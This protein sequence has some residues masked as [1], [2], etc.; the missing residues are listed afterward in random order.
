MK[1]FSIRNR[2]EPRPA[3]RPGLLAPCHCYALATVLLW[4]SAYVFTK[5][6]MEHFSFASLG[7][8]RCA[9]A[10]VVLAAALAVKKT[11]RP[12]AAELPWF[13][14]SGAAGFA[15]Y[16]LAFNRGSVW[17]NPTT[18]CL[19]ISTAPLITALLARFGLGEGLTA[20]GWGALLSAFGGVAIMMLGEGAVT[21]S[22]GIFWMLL[23]ALLISVYNLV[24]RKLAAGR[25][26]LTITAYSFFS[27]A[28]LLAWGAP[29]ALE[30]GLEASPG[31]LAVAVYLGVFPSALAYLLWV[32]ALALAPRTSAVT[33]YMYLTPL[34]ALLLEYLILAETPGLGTWLGGVVILGS[35]VLFNRKGRRT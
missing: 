27:A 24:Q 4:S 6:A 21:F 18:S 19:V 7:F 29:R 15:L 16:L 32:K 28:I 14:L 34:L 11:P 13:I 9:V 25:D 3:E 30:E 26:S 20:A 33:S 17:L 23:A 12:P 31:H 2:P 1:G 10:S 5:V 35:L 22:R 8:L